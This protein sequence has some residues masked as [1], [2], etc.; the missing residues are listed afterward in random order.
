MDFCIKALFDGVKHLAS[1]FVIVGYA[2]A[3]LS[4]PILF[5]CIALKLFYQI[6]KILKV[7]YFSKKFCT[8][9]LMRICAKCK[10]TTKELPLWYF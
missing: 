2:V 8:K 9:F 10:N 7:K 1:L 3:G 4:A 6:F 5:A